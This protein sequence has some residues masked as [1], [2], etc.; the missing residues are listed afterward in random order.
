MSAGESAVARFLTGVWLGEN[1]YGF[2]I[3]IQIQDC[4]DKARQALKHGWT[5][6]FFH[7]N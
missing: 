7:R 2:D 1:K 4:D 3:I 6:H 5:I